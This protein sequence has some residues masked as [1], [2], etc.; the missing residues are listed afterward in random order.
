MHTPTLKR[1]LNSDLDIQFMRWV[2]VLIFAI[3]GYA[4][5]FP[6]EAQGLV[7]II[8]NSPLLS[9][10]HPAFGTQGASYALGIAEW[11][12]GLGLLIGAWLPRVSVVAAA[13][14][15]ITYLTTLTLIFTTPDAWEVSAGGFPAMGGHTSFLI[16]DAVLL[17]GSIQLLKTS[18]LQVL[19][20]CPKL[21]TLTA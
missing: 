14:S 10:M 19:A 8:A 7:P 4:K 21:K 15:C 11:S 16:K 5:W 1:L 20:D 9:W 17:A 18:L 13:A 6:Y 2:L 3:F 12:I